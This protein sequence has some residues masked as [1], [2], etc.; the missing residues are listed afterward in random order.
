MRKI[1]TNKI[2]K[3]MIDFYEEDGEIFF[4]PSS[5][6]KVELSEKEKY[7]IER[8]ADEIQRRLPL[9]LRKVHVEKLLQKNKEELKKAEETMLHVNNS[10]GELA[11]IQQ[12][13]FFNDIFDPR[14]QQGLEEHVKTQLIIQDKI[15]ELALEED[16]LSDEL[17]ESI[18]DLKRSIPRGTYKEK[19]KEKK[20]FLK[21]FQKELEE[22]LFED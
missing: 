19:Q 20:Q 7:L 22:K 1:S 2:G 16:N 10:I 6:K 14:I 15:G 13:Q 5:Q 17:K 4:S 11:E 12:G 8:K 18:L 3:K 9:Y 21:E